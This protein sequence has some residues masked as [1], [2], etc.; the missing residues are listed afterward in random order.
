MDVLRIRSIPH[1]QNSIYHNLDIAGTLDFFTRRYVQPLA[2]L[3]DTSNLVV[4][5]CGAGY[6]WFSIAYLLAGGKAAIA[7]D[8]DTTRLSAAKDIAAILSVDDRLKFVSSPIQNIPLTS[9]SVDVLVSIETLEHVGRE[10]TRAALQR[11]KDIASQ[12]VLITTPNRLFP[13]VAHDTR[14]PFA[15]WLPSSMREKYARML[16]RENMNEDSKFLSPFDLGVLLDK[17]RPSS[18]CLAF[19]S[20]EEYRNHFPVYLPYGSEERK[21]LRTRPSAAKAAYYRIACTMLGNHSYWVMPS[22]AR[23]FVR[24]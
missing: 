21:R 15:H 20:F 18:S 9:N 5:D 14:L 4:A 10:N 3:F 2:C 22:L 24:K 13:A 6:G 7:I 8:P 19:Q 16:N 1:L 23:I 11:I 17:F 12:G